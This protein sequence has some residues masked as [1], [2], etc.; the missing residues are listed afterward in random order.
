MVHLSHG[1]MP[2]VV[3]I[4]KGLGHE[5]YDEPSE[6]KKHEYLGLGAK[7]KFLAGK[8]VNANSLMGVV[9]DP[10]SGLCATWGIRAKLTRV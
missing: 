1:I 4:P 8:G 10:V 7:G 2:G 5:G 3:A 6:S 9:E